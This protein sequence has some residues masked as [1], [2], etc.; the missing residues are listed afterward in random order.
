M[1]QKRCACIFY[2]QNPAFVVID[3]KSPSIGWK[4]KRI[5]IPAARNL[6]ADLI[7]NE[8]EA[9]EVRGKRAAALAAVEGS[10]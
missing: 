7:A 1:K 4:S 10:K 9:E 2:C 8:A 3:F 5:C 6:L